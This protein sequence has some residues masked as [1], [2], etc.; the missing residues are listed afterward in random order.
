[1]REVNTERRVNVSGFM[2]LLSCPFISIIEDSWADNNTTI[3]DNN[4]AEAKKEAVN[5]VKVSNTT[6]R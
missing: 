2:L 3:Y 1:M 5:P 4:L 6:Q